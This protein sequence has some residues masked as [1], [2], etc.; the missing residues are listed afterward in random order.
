MKYLFLSILILVL[1]GACED[2][3]VFEPSHYFCDSGIDN[4]TAGFD[5]QELQDL[6][7]EMVASGVPG[8]MMSV[9]YD[10][11][12]R[13]SGSSGKADL[14]NNIDLSPCNIT[15]VGSTVKTFTAIA[16]L[17]LQEEGKLHLDD[18]VSQYLDNNILQGLANAK[19]AS[20]RQLL[21]HSSGI[22]NYIANPRFQTA[23][24]NDLTKTWQPKELL[25][26]ARNEAAE[27]SPGSDVQYSN[28][29]Y[30]LLGKI[31]EA[32]EQKPFY[33]VFAERIFKPLNL[34][35]TRF[36]A[37]DPIPDGIIQGYIDL[38]SNLN[39]IN[40]T[41]YSGW[42]Y[43]TAD[44]GLISNSNDLNVFL[45][46]LF[47]GYIIQESSLNEMI[48]WKAPKKQDSETFDTYY[49][50]GIFRIDTD[51]GPAYMHSGDAIG[52]FASMVYFPNYNVTITWATN[53]NYGKIDDFT[54]SKEAMEKIFKTL[55]KDK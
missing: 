19:Q 35:N 1:F 38:Y 40:S 2:D 36:A 51:F 30:I 49:G 43:F 9:N 15:R 6:I 50:L 25:D 31:I 5:Y 32:I 10:D 39:V 41:E 48:T 14:A 21:Q 17:L 22:Y 27:F 12:I 44:G 26:Y 8:V 7:D 16:I 42:D 33:E 53:G 54:Q 23:S 46:Q 13:W 3:P 24:L 18:L 4:I 37:T 52:Y 34:S 20:I 28:T 47:N 11:T 45:H 55:L 29:N